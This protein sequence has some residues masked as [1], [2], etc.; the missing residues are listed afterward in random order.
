MPEADAPLLN[1][2][3]TDEATRTLSSTQ[4]TEGVQ[5]GGGAAAAPLCGR[6]PFDP[7]GLLTGEYPGS[8]EGP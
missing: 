1:V 7:Q 4:E 6:G 8:F 3:E 5:D 2:R